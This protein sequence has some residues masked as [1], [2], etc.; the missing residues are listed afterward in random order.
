MG[1]FVQ[2]PPPRNKEERD[3]QI[4]FYENFSPAGRSQVVVYVLA[5]LAVVALIN[6]LI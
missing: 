5:I 6:Y 3:R 1:S 4:E 2:L